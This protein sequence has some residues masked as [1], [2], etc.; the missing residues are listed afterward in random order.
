MTNA[1]VSRVEEL[2]L[3]SQGIT[4]QL[5]YELAPHLADKFVRFEENEEEYKQLGVYAR[6]NSVDKFRVFR[7][8]G[9]RFFPRFSD[10]KKY[11][12]RDTL[13]NMVNDEVVYPFLLFINKS[14]VRWSRI[15]VLRDY[16]YTYLLI[17]GLKRHEEVSFNII[18]MPCKIRYGE[19][20]D[21]LPHT[22]CQIGIYFNR[23]G[24]IT[25]GDDIRARVEILD[26]NIFA[27][28]QTVTVN[29]PYISFSV[30]GRQTAISSIICFKDGIIDPEGTDELKY[31]GWNA[32]ANLNPDDYGSR[33]Y[34]VFYNTRS[35][36]SV[37]HQYTPCL[38]QEFNKRY[39]LTYVSNTPE[40]LRELFKLSEF[41]FTY[42][43]ELSFDENIRNS[44]TYI[45]DFDANLIN[46]AY[47]KETDIFIDHYTGKEIK[48]HAKAYG[49]NKNTMRISR[50]RLGKFDAMMLMFKNGLLYDEYDY[51]NNHI[52]ISSS[53]MKDSDKIDMMFTIPSYLPPLTIN[54]PDENTPIYI[55]SEYDLSRCRLFTNE[56]HDLDYDVFKIDPDGRTQFQL[57]F[58]CEKHEGNMYYFF[59]EDPYFYGRDITLVPENMMVTHR[60]TLADSDPETDNDYYF[61][62]PTDFNYC[63]GKNHYL[64]F[65]NGIMLS[66]QNFTITEP[67]TTRP[68]DKIYLYITTHL[69]ANDVLDVVY[70]P[71]EFYDEIWFDKLDLTGDVVVDGSQNSVPLSTDNYLIFVNGKLICSNDVINIDRNRVRIKSSYD[72]INS[73]LFMRYNHRIEEIEEIFAQ[74]TEDEWSRYIDSLPRYNLN[75]VINNTSMLK[76]GTADNYMKDHYELST[77][78]SDIVFDFYMKRAGL[79]L[80]NKVFVYD[81]ETEAVGIDTGCRSLAINTTDSG[82]HDKMYQYWYNSTDAELEGQTF[83]KSPVDNDP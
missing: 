37:N 64:V 44:L 29:K 80:T 55:K 25:Y 48:N 39:S 51:N 59:L 11:S 22:E 42:D 31:V 70:M 1:T 7:V 35:N 68:F 34:L 9:L 79:N 12:R 46:Q 60:I 53:G 72:S 71:C 15:E 10:K 24:Y 54:I 69:D 3:A 27:S 52:D 6:I 82:R 19:D 33:R 78:V 8:T 32:Y 83:D 43:K 61:L 63:H 56:K 26:E 77:I 62:L 14:F 40:Y 13:E 2:R 65:L 45:M 58:T 81:F 49:P 16:E 38:D 41:N 28:Y 47:K 18:E 76:P 74:T 20:D 4:N 5:Q 75:R 57:V 73:V 23:Y 21:I 30:G 17:S 67:R 66:R 36:L 50:R